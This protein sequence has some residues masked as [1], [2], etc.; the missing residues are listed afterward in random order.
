MH[1][2]QSVL[3]FLSFTDL[4]S[5]LLSFSIFFFFCRWQIWWL[6]GSYQVVGLAVAGFVCRVEKLRN[7]WPRK[8]ANL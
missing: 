5:V 1:K 8:G 7:G 2:Q 3:I 4:L 6:G